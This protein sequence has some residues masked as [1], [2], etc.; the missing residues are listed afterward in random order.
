MTEVRAITRADCAELV[1]EVHYAKRWPSISYA[2]GLFEG[3]DLLGV[4]TF[5]TPV[6]STLRTGLAGPDLSSKVLELNR[7]CLYTNGPNM[8]STLVGGALRLLKQSGDWIVISF[9]DN[10]QGHTGYIYQA[11]NFTY[12]GLSAKRT[13]WKVRGFEHLHSA[14]IADFTRGKPNRAAL[15][16]ERYGD[17]F[18]LKPRSRKHRYVYLVGSKKFKKAARA[19]LRYPQEPY[20]KLDLD[21]MELLQ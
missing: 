11:T 5:G 8:A 10:A 17:D 7:L 18:Y 16:R 1:L 19:A 2:F 14:T 21:T 6:S 3:T 13:D 9:A 15:M 4:A 20:P 12:H